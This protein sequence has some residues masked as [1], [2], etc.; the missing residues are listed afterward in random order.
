M[1][2][3]KLLHR[4]DLVGIRV[5]TSEQACRLLADGL[6]AGVDDDVVILVTGRSHVDATVL[7]VRVVRVVESYDTTHPVACDAAV[8]VESGAAVLHSL[9]SGLVDEASEGVG[10]V[11]DV[12]VWVVAESVNRTP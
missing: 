8:S 3:F 1:A 7:R 10:E 11:A 9:E 12:A 2:V 5:G 4:I 6:P